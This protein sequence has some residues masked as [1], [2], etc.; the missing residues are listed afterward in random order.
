MP[1]KF[2]LPKGW[3]R[4]PAKPN[5]VDAEKVAFAAV[6]PHPGTGAGG[7]VD[8]PSSPWDSGARPWSPRSGFLAPTVA[9]APWRRH[10][11]RSMWCVRPSRRTRFPGLRAVPGTRTPLTRPAFRTGRYR[12]PRLRR[13]V[14]EFNPHRPGLTGLGRPPHGRRPAASGRAA[15]ARGAAVGSARSGGRSRADPGRFDRHRHRLHGHRDHGPGRQAAPHQDHSAAGLLGRSDPAVPGAVLPARF[16]GQPGQS[17]LPRPAQFHLD[18]HGD[19]GRRGEG[20]VRR[21]A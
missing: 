7:G 4:R 1:T 3:L 6:H 9:S 8:T 5:E 21:L 16:T 20:L 2:R 12:S 10:R 13:T 11:E 19:P 18:D 17:E 14:D 15:R